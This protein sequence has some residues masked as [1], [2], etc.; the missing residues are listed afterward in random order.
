[1]SGLPCRLETVTKKQFINIPQAVAALA[2]MER[3]LDSAESYARFASSRTRP[4]P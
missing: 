2:N 1:M 3:E 4:K